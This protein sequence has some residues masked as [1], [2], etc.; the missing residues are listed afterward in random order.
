[1]YL[2]FTSDAKD[3]IEPSVMLQ[4]I[5]QT[6]VGRIAPFDKVEFWQEIGSSVWGSNI[7]PG[8]EYSYPVTQWLDF[9]AKVY[10]TFSYCSASGWSA[11]FNIDDGLE[12]KINQRFST[13]PMISWRDPFMKPI[14]SPI[15]EDWAGSWSFYAHF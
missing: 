5:F 7:Y 8:V 13:G 9:F 15:K 1:M 3:E 10:G 6:S 11:L 2:N 12:Y 14:G 4:R